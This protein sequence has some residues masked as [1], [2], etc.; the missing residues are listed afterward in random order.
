[1]RALQPPTKFVRVDIPYLEQPYQASATE[2]ATGGLTMQGL[3]QVVICYKW[4]QGPSAVAMHTTAA[5]MSSF[6]QQG[7]LLFSYGEALKP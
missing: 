7:C 2:R 4:G 6:P 5:W 1:M 3:A